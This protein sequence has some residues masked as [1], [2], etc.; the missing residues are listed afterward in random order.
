MG[1]FF[2]KERARCNY[3]IASI[4]LNGISGAPG[5]LVQSANPHVNLRTK[6]NSKINMVE[7]AYSDP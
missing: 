5:I 6:G 4:E 2:L 3:Q 1:S 7:K